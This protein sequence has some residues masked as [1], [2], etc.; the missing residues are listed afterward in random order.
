MFSERLSE[1]SRRKFLQLTAAGVGAASMSGW[2]EVLAARA[3]AA[4]APT[5]AK[6]R[7]CILLWMDGGPSHKDTLDLK[8][9]SKGA[10]DFKPIQTSAPG[11]EISEHLPGF[12]KVMKHGVLVRGMS[13]P[14]GAH[15]RA[16]YNLHTGYREG[17]G[18]LIYP[19][20]GSIV[21]AETGKPESSVPA[22][23]SIGSRS[24]GSGFL[25]PKYQPLLVQDPVRGVEDLKAV[26][27][28]ARFDK[29]VTLLE[30][31]ET[32]FQGEYRAG[33]ITD[34]K[35]T[36]ERA[37]KL[38]HSKEAKAFD[39]TLEPAA[40]KSKY[41]TGKFAEGVLMARRLVEIGVPFVEVTLGGWDTHQDNFD[42]VKALSGQID[43]PIA[44][45]IEDLKARGLL[46]RTLVVWMGEFGR[47]PNINTRGAKPGR[48]HY[49]KAWSLAM[50]GGGVRGGRVVGKTDAD[51]AAVVDQKV[52]TAD[53]LATVC[54]LMGIDHTKKNDTPAGRPISIVDK[55]KPFTSLIV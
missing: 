45:L 35:T 42:K 14:E 9:G 50:F 41:G 36:Y 30:E 8:P 27:G 47:T 44:A 26:V 32:A 6:A 13:T 25:G 28:D 1:L 46:D 40:D 17:Q 24:F 5:A 15:P 21:A 4:P 3:G 52:G 48:D 10:G 43:P 20:I 54:E 12:A 23:V 31:M 33:A 49:P 18:G 29:R 51:G 11:I 38:M 34:H 2:L 22:F 39:L 7:S 37:V 55:P 19:S 53:F 16:K